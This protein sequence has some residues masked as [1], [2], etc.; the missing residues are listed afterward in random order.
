M[1]PELLPLLSPGVTGICISTKT[2]KLLLL[3]CKLLTLGVAV[4]GRAQ[5]EAGLDDAG[6]CLEL[7]LQEHPPPLLTSL[8]LAASAHQGQGA[9]AAGCLFSLYDA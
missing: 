8:L 1:H 9:S 5:I 3:P 7:L 4:L 6:L 2:I